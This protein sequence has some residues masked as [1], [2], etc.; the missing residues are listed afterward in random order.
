M[1][2]GWIGSCL[3]SSEG[4]GIMITELLSTTGGE[5]ESEYTLNYIRI[6]LPSI[7]TGEH[8]AGRS[9]AGGS[10]L[11]IILPLLVLSTDKL[12]KGWT[13]FDRI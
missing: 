3:Y 10:G 1:I 6:V 8:F 5:D 11:A 9:T 2:L 13:C 4:I 12:S 7:P